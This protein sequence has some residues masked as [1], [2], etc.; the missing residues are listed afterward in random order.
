MSIWTDLLMFHGYVV[1]RGTLALL[2]GARDAARAVTV[3][4]PEPMPEDGAACAVSYPPHPLRTV[5]QL[6]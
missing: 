5:C 3:V 2:T 6:R 4:A 1:D